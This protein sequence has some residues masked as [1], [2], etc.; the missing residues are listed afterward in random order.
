MD[1]TIFTRSDWFFGGLLFLLTFTV[2][3]ATLCPTVYVEGSGELIS[4]IH[5]LGIA[6]PTGYPLLCLIGRMIDTIIP[7]GSVAWRINLTSALLG[8]V[9]VSCSLSHRPSGHRQS[10]LR[11]I[12]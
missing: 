11:S 8:A 12:P 3:L 7:F 2:Y 9:V 6:H 10:S 5:L 4:S 1:K